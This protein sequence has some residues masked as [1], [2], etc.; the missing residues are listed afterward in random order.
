MT[1]YPEGIPSWRFLINDGNIRF[2]GSFFR[3]LIAERLGSLI[4]TVGG[5][6]LFIIGLIKKPDK[7]EAFFY[8]SWLASVI[9]YF[10]VFA[11]GNVRHDYYQIPA[12]PILA[13]FMTLGTKALFDSQNSRL[14]TPIARITAIVLILFTFA[15]GFYQVRGFYWINR[16]EIIEAG[17]AVDRVIPKDA[18]VIAPYNGDTAFLYQTNRYGYPIVDR[19]F[20]QYLKEG[21]KY[22]V[23]VDV[24][25][26]GI[27]NFA[28][29]CYVIEKTDNYIIIEL[30]QDCIKK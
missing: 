23:S 17:K 27:Q 10:I 6:S 7:K 30:S 18:A 28:K 14:I 24:N 22:L 25:D 9:L 19:P 8:Y 26:S 16:P 11:S 4:L 12:I 1:R 13:V 2:K 15:F 3:W 5:F 21:T 20:E 29:N